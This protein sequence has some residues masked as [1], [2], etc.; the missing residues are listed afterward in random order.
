[1]RRLATWC[2]S[3]RRIVV[4][5][6][7]AAF[8]L[9]IAISGAIGP[10]YSTNFSLK[11]TESTRAFALL[12]RTEKS[13]SGDVDQIVIQ[14]SGGHHV[15]DQSVVNEFAVVLSRVA[16]LKDVSGVVVPYAIGRFPV[17]PSQ[18]S[19]D[20]TIAYATVHFS[21]RGFNVSS[22]A[23]RQFV[24]TGTSF[25]KSYI[26]SAVSGQIA[27]QA[28]RPT[29]GGLWIGMIAA[30]IVLFLVFGSVYASLMPLASAVVA[31]GSATAVI[32]ML[33]HLVAMPEFTANLAWLIGLGV[34]VD[35]ALFIVTRHRQGLMEGRAV[36]ESIVNAV[37]TS[38]RAVLFAGIIVCVAL[39]GM[40][41]I[42]VNFLYGVAIAAAIGVAFTMIAALTFLP[43][44]LGFVGPG[45][46]SRRTRANLVVSGH[47]ESG[48][49]SSGFWSRWSMF[50]SRRPIVPAALSLVLI[51]I[52]AWPFFSMRLGQSD[53][54]NDAVGSTTRTAY[55]LVAKGFG[56]GVNGP[57][58]I[59]S[60]RSTPQ[61][62]ELAQLTTKLTTMRDV[63]HVSTTVLPAKGGG[64][65][66]VILVTPHSAPQSAATSNLITDIRQTVIPSI[67]PR[68]SPKVY[69]GGVTAVF[70][71]FSHVLGTKLPLFIGLVV[72]VSFLLLAIVFRSIVVPLMSA[73]MNVI[74]IGAAFGVVT[75]VFQWGWA[76]ALIGVN[77]AGP[78]DAFLPVMMFAIL[79]G[80]AMDY[81]V[82]LLVRVHEEWVASGDN[83]TAIQIGLARTGKTIT[84]AALIMI[85]VFASFILGGQRVIKEFGLGLAGGVLVDAII[86]R[87]SIVP[88]VMFLLGRANWWFPKVLDRVVPKIGLEH[89]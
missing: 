89:D 68:G 77:R 28:D 11:G 8:I 1:M 48:D 53:Q 65:L 29:V 46:L 42:G 10:S 33:S 30:L 26:L 78:I 54:G 35:Y 36:E 22:A 6:W 87:M 20:R 66:W 27:E 75:A 25:H 45:I 60:L 88:A 57:L 43:A 63:A 64:Y 50:I 34:G 81:Q 58:Q 79:F 44:M 16:T 13:I 59:V 85:V 61:S 9:T 3:H 62:P 84:A 24:A 17:A 80:L 14:T 2:V 12:A 15:T 19:K 23:A 83:R 73:I 18:I 38:G 49:L 86:I 69:V 76:G 7:L 51:A 31:L 4:S 55:D 72:G 56:P 71:D 37:N 32:S 67:M 5:A 39:L 52:I 70:I 41:A 47:R 40:F 82:F 21:V 74:S